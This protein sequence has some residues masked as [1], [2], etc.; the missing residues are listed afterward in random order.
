MRCGLVLVQ[1]I[2]TGVEISIHG[3]PINPLDTCAWTLQFRP[4]TVTKAGKSTTAR[5]PSS[6]LGFAV[7]STL[8]TT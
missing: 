6:T 4:R 8:V 3:T 7:V 1:S 5:R 2:G